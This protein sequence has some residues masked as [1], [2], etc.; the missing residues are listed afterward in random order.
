MVGWNASGL[1][2]GHL[3]KNLVS[4]FSFPCHFSCMDERIAESSGESAPP[5]ESVKLSILSRVPGYGQFL[6]NKT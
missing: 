2:E 5:L 4:S 1:A 6:S 3:L